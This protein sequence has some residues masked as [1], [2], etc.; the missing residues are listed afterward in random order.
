MPNVQLGL[1]ISDGFLL[2]CVC[3]C[4]SV[5]EE[6]SLVAC[7]YQ[8]IFSRIFFS[9]FV[10]FFFFYFFSFI[11][12]N[13]RFPCYILFNIFNIFNILRLYRLCHLKMSFSMFACTFDM[14]IKLLLT[15]LLTYLKLIY[16]TILGIRTVTIH[17]QI[18]WLFN[19]FNAL[20]FPWNKMVILS[21]PQ[22]S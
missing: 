14:C 1:S 7:H 15:Y 6:C 11:I 20:I 8:L 18:V 9:F 12:D 2:N 13:Y 19:R 16:H 21:P 10:L 5:F 3:S 22:T 4:W 17:W